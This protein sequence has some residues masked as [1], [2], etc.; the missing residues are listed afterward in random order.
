MEQAIAVIRKQGDKYCIFSKK[1]K[2]LSCHP[3]R[4]AALKR[5][6]QIEFFKHQKGSLASVIDFLKYYGHDFEPDIFNEMSIAEYVAKAKKD[7]KCMHGKDPDECEECME[8]EEEAESKKK[9]HMSKCADDIAI[10][11]LMVKQT[12]I[13]K[14][15]AGCANSREEATT[16]AKKHGS[17][18]TIRET[19]DSY[20]FRQRPP[21]D[22]DQK[23]FRTVK[24]SKCVTYVLGKLKGE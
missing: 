13:V 22:F 1:G 14:K 4:E 18:K 6:R 21:S 20:R 16:H 24:V 15:G 17:T 12:V 10:S 3:S 2:R 19:G 8:D 7:E 23:T 5:L 9:K 11:A